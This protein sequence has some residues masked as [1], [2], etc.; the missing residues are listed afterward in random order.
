MALGENASDT[1]IISHDLTLQ[2]NSF[3][4]VIMGAIFTLI[5]VILIVVGLF[6]MR[7]IIFNNIVT[8]SKKIATLK[9]TGFSSNNIISLYLFEYGIIAFFSLIIGIFGSLALS[10]VVLSDLNEL[11]NMFGLSNSVNLFQIAIVF[12]LLLVIIEF[13]V[14][15]V[16]RG[17]S[18]IKPAVALN[19]G[20]QVHETKSVFSLTKYKRM[21]ISL[22]LAIKDIFYNKKMII[23][24]IL[25]IIATTFTIVSLSSASYSL[26]SQKEN[27]QLWLGYD[28]DA[29]V[30]SSTPIDAELHQEIIETLEAS[31]Y[32]E[33]TVTSYLDLTSQIYDDNQAKYLGSISQ[34]FVT[35]D[36]EPLD[37]SVIDGRL[38]ENEN[39][40][41]IANNLLS[42]LNKDLGDY[43]TVRSL[44]IEK[45]LLIVGESQ[46]FTNQGMTFRIFLDEIEDEFLVNS[47]IQINF[48]DDVEED[49]LISEIATIF[50]S[51]MTLVF[52]YANAS[53][54]SMLDILS[55]VTTGVISIFAVICLVVLLNFNKRNF[56]CKK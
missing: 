30:V 39:E 48:I 17:V 14:Y 41:M 29:K 35:Q 15:L 12:I 21:P 36:K 42:T 50:S 22:V 27:N 19:R 46:S 32:I 23:T 7:S 44:G 47:L 38:P 25:F 53:M 55:L 43:V 3:F 26:N 1:Q 6:I 49:V 20:E 52:E 40:I 4:Q 10:D 24:L 31:E 9:S 37:F 11:S 8:E 2:A 34:I 13:T 33:G 51:D 56:C 18:K 5:G 28:I 45:E 16:A 54:L